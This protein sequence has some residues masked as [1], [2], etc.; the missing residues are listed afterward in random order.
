MQS[1]GAS[2]NRKTAGWLVPAD[3]ALRSSSCFAGEA[4]AI[5]LSPPAR[6][7]NSRDTCS[8]PDDRHSPAASRN[9][10]CKR[11]WRSADR[12]SRALPSRI[13]KHR[14][15]RRRPGTETESP[16]WVSPGFSETGNRLPQPDIGES[17]APGRPELEIPVRQ[18]VAN[19][20]GDRLG[21]RL[22]ERRDLDRLLGKPAVGTMS[23]TT[24]NEERSHRNMALLHFREKQERTGREPSERRRLPGRSAGWDYRSN[25]G[26]KQFNWRNDPRNCCG[27]WGRPSGLSRPWPSKACP[28][29]VSRLSSH[30]VGE[31]RIGDNFVATGM[32]PLVQRTS[33]D[34][35]EAR[36][37][38]TRRVANGHAMGRVGR[39]A[40]WHR[41]VFQF[42]LI[43]RWSRRQSG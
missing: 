27:S 29:R 9:A 32:V 35:R 21:R 37:P 7:A 19:C 8:P 42:R 3:S 36:P 22:L 33:H 38:R 41:M 23:K 26:P 43:R 17:Y 31:R 24:R 18:S 20:R 16:P 10:S 11:P 28:E 6:P 5:D 39:L 25:R 4:P 14:P 34:P 13:V 15:T 12:G 30:R 1:A 2:S 40:S